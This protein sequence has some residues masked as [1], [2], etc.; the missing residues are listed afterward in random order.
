[1][2]ESVVIREVAAATEGP[3]NCRLRHVLT[4][5]ADCKCEVLRFA[6]DDMIV[7]TLL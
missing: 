3:L 2:K 4:R 6:Q 7:L 1:M 5:A